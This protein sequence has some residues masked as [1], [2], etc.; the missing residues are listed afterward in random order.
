MFVS[1]LY[2]L[3]RI[4]FSLSVATLINRHVISPVQRYWVWQWWLGPNVLSFVVKE[5]V[6]YEKA[7]THLW[8]GLIWFDS[9]WFGVLWY[10]SIQFNSIQFDS[11]RFDL[12]SFDLIRFS[13]VRLDIVYNSAISSEMNPKPDEQSRCDSDRDRFVHCHFFGGSRCVCDDYSS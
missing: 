1:I 7:S 8:F 6:H 4:L 2:S 13:S 5:W 3:L 9:I 11:I 12:I 10:D